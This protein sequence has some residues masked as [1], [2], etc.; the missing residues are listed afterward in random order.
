MGWG[1]V[2]CGGVRGGVGW[3]WQWGLGVGGLKFWESAL[4]S[5]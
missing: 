3:G 1:G 4:F 2:G 5:G